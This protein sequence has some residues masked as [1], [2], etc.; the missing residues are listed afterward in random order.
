MNR[1]LL[2][3]AAACAACTSHNGAAEA[4]LGAPVP[5][6][7]AGGSPERAVASSISEVSAAELDSHQAST[8]ENFLR[9][10]IA[11]LSMLGNSGQ[12]GAG[13]T[14]RL[15]G[16]HSIL[17][18]SRPLIYVDGVRVYS[19]FGPTTG[20]SMQAGSPLSDIDPAQI[21]RIEVLKGPAAT[22]LY[23]TEAANGVIRIFTKRGF[24]GGV[25]AEGNAMRPAP[26][27]P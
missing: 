9:G 2:I 26:R 14:M 13:A 21:E 24:G 4:G 10:R 7:D 23:G 17:Q 18:E 16:N 5:T 12:P 27:T 15:R 8:V 1:T 3:L 19:G 11:G 20:G 25:A 6:A 22:T